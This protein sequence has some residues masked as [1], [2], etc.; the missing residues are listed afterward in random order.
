MWNKAAGNGLLL[1]LFT[2]LCRIASQVIALS[3]TASAGTAV[4]SGII[5]LLQTGGCIWIMKFFMER[6][7][8]QYDGVDSRDTARY[9][10]MLA[11]TSSLVFAGIMLADIVY[12]F[13]ETAD[14]QLSLYR[15]LYGEQ[16]DANMR[17]ALKTIEDNYPK[18]MFF[19]TLIYSWLY[20]VIL[21]AVLSLTIPGKDPFSRF[22]NKQ[23]GHPD[24]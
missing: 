16:M 12:I 9:G 14:T 5:W 7:V 19:S 23:G 21:S 20:G 2:A 18:I 6:L 10:R 15:Q 17:S 22:M 13:P 4:L 8:R 11:L 3:G 24:E 1:G